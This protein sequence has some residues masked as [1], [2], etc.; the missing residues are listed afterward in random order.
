M[1]A[2]LKLSDGID[3]IVSRIGKWAALLA[4]PLMLTIMFDVIQRKFGGQG[5]IKLQELEWHLHTGLFMLCFGFGYIRDSHVRIELIRDNLRPRTRAIVEMIGAIICIL[6]FCALVIYFGYDFVL[7][8]FENHEVSASTTGLTH[9]WLIKSTI[10]I[11]FGLLA[12]AGFSVFLK[13]YVFVFGPSN[14]RSRAGHYVGATHH[15]DLGNEAARL[16]D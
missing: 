4:I 8:S 3:A 13:C 9:R 7:R 11:G 15:A 14:L 16:K 1:E 12:M 10:P 5:S 2:L 6:P